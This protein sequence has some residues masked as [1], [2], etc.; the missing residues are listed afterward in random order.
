[1][2]ALLHMHIAAYHTVD[3]KQEPSKHDMCVTKEPPKIAIVMFVL[4]MFT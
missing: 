4:M 2:I 1:M 3:V